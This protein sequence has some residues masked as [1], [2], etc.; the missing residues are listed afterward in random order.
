MK[1]PFA[2]RVGKGAF[3]SERRDHIHHWLGLP[4]MK[5]HSWSRVALVLTPLGRALLET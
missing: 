2:L 3:T 4:A 5:S 1:A